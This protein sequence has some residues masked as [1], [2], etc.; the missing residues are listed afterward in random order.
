MKMGALFCW[1]WNIEATEILMRL[2]SQFSARSILV[3]PPH[4]QEGVPSRTSPSAL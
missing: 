1:L 2:Y 4:S 3:S